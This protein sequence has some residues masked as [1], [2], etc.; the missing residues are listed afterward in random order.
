MSLLTLTT[1]SDA[2]KR[3]PLIGGLWGYFAAALV[4]V[5]QH[6]FKSNEK[7]NKGQ[8]LHWSIDKSNDHA[9]C[10]GRHMLDIQELLALFERGGYTPGEIGRASC[11]ERVCSTV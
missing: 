2:R 7:H 9:E 6:S 3:I 1:D 5:A 8:P 4:G 11:R 10:C